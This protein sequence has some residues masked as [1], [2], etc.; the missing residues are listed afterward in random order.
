M[1]YNQA[2]TIFEQHLLEK[3]KKKYSLT[4]YTITKIPSHD[5]GRNLVYTC[6][7]AGAD[8]K[9]IRISFQNDRTKEDYLAE[10]EFVRY[11][12]ENSASVANVVDTQNGDLLSILEWE[13]HTFFVAVFVKAKGEIFRDRNYQYRDGVPI[14]EYFF[15]CGKTLGKIHQLSKTYRLK[16]KRYSFFEKYTVS[17]ISKLVPKQ[18]EKLKEKLLNI[19]DEFKSQDRNSSNYGLVHFDFNDGN[20]MIDFDTGNITVF[21]FDNCCYCSFMFDLASLWQNGVGWT[22]WEKDVQKRH[23]FM[24]HYFSVVLE[25]YRSETEL[26]NRELEKLPFFIMVNLLEMTLA[27]FEDGDKIEDDEELRYFCKCIEDDIPF[28]GFFSELYSYEQP[29]CLN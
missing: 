3:I 6:V 22:I 25:G 12:H 19:V 18:Y 2:K 1:D 26:N 15:N 23:E 27:R 9:I 20:Y 16:H 10:L 28:S 11:L 4:G 29:F 8:D 13:N 5:G 7:N 21:D 24:T 17:Y 14:E